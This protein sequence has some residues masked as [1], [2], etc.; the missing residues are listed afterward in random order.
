MNVVHKVTKIIQ[1]QTAIVIGPTGLIG[2]QLVELL[3]QDNT[4][5]EVRILVRNP[6][7][8]SHP[9][10][11][12]QTVR[13]NDYHDIK[14]KIGTGYSIFCCIGTTQKKV[15]GDKIA[16]RK[17]DY[18][19]PLNAAHAGLENGVKKYL[20]VSAAGA[21]EKSSNFYLQLKGSVE[22]EISKLGFESINFFKP[23]LLLGTRKEF[24]A[25]EKVAQGF[26]P[27]VS[28]L[29][30]GPLKKYKPIQSIDVAKAMIAVAKRETSG[31]NAYE[32]SEMM[33][34]IGEV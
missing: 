2:S 7:S 24:R 19:I 1:G 27:L 11:D 20:L 34:L 8:L 30:A 6:L 33:K 31:V 26:L 23:S 14:E 4:F 9:K 10:L 3:L 13:F 12:V 5:T 17:V 29:F 25:G 21:N 15:H 16:Y 22:N 32:Y 28:F 18:T